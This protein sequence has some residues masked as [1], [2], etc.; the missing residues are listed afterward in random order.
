MIK[1]IYSR[2]GNYPFE[3]FSPQKIVL[4]ETEL[5]KLISFIFQKLFL[6]FLLNFNE[7]IFNAVPKSGFLK[8]K[9]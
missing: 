8:I 7:G 9:I 6:I 2:L 3:K 1:S 4:G 5:M